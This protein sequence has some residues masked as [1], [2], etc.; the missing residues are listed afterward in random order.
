MSEAPRSHVSLQHANAI[1]IFAR[2]TLAIVTGFWFT[3]ALLSGAEQAGGGMAGII[4]NAPNAL[5][6][7]ALIVLNV[8]AWRWEL[9]GGG[10]IILLGVVSIF[11]FNVLRGNFAVFY[12]ISLP[13]IALGVLFIASWTLRRKRYTPKKSHE[14]TTSESE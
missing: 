1:R 14:D 11:A 13:L 5:P 2:I 4:R 9:A 8:I 7:V 12:Y 6:W 10:V 3:F